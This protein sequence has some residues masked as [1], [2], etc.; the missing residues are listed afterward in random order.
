M[1]ALLGQLAELSWAWLWVVNATLPKAKGVVHTLRWK[2][3]MLAI[4]VSISLLY[5]QRCRLSLNVIFLIKKID[6]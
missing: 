5:G 4:G 3:A 2:W 6:I 1:I